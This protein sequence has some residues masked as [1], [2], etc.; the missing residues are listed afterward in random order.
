MMMMMVVVAAGRGLLGRPI[1]RWKDNI[2]IV[3]KELEW[4]WGGVD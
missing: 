1:H 3:H 4:W 2:N